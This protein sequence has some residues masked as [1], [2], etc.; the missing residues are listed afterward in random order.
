MFNADQ[1]DGFK[2][3]VQP[4]IAESDRIL[5]AQHF[6]INTGARVIEGG[7]RAHCQS[8]SDEIH[9]PPFQAFKKPDLFYSTLAHECVHFTANPGRCNR[10]LGNRFG[11]EAYAMEKLI[12]ELGSAFLSADLHLD[13]EPRLGNAPYMENWLRTLKMTSVRFLRQQA[14]RSKQGAASY[15]MAHQRNG[16]L[17][18]RLDH[19]AILV[20]IHR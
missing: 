13:T 10:Q 11:S 9:I 7:N 4:L 14:R 6:F 5:N 15:Q 19:R 18:G 16:A 8:A 2:V 3:P 1:V 17:G 12:A 20:G